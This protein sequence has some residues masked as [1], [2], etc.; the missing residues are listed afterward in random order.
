MNLG[1]VKNIQK[2]RLNR[3]KRRKCTKANKYN[4]NNGVRFE[5][6]HYAEIVDTDETE[7]LSHIR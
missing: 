6:L 3:K 7:V 5:N 4:Q 2:L 1:A